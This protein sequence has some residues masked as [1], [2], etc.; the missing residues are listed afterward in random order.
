M[1]NTLSFPPLIKNGYRM[2]TQ[3]IFGRNS[4]LLISN[5]SLYKQSRRIVLF[6]ACHL[7][8]SKIIDKAFLSVPENRTWIVIYPTPIKKSSSVEIAKLRRFLIKMKPDLV[9]AVGGGTVLDVTKSA[10]ILA[11]NKGSIGDYLKGVREMTNP[12]ISV[13]AVPTT[14][15]TGSEVTPWA[16]IWDYVKKKKYSLSSPNMFPKMA[17]V[18]PS[19]TDSMSTKVTAETGFDALTQAIE[20]FWSVKH[21]PVSDK[22]ALEAIR[23]LIANLPLAV[24]KPDIKVRDNMMRA[25]LLTGLAFSNTQTTLCHSVSYPLTVRF[26]VTHGQAVAITLPIFLEYIISDYDRK[27]CK[28]L[29]SALKTGNGTEARIKLTELMKKVGLK[30]TLSD[31]GISKRDLTVIVKDGFDPGRAKNSPKMP[32]RLKLK[33]LLESIY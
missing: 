3:V 30:T 2:P 8:G 27:R 19:L 13:I 16:V 28:L 6:L 5:F 4:L 32:T 22:Y 31:L 23:I 17:V 12:G 33:Q 1:T 21:N 29:L 24:N 14:A 9:V 11:N 18:D 26:G 7:Q 15:G 25:S 10:A 20:A